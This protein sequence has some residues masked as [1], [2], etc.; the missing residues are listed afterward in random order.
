MV[1]AAAEAA[2]SSAGVYREHAWSDDHLRY[3]FMLLAELKT[4]SRA[5]RRG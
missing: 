2:I 5:A 1:Y 4:F 3:K